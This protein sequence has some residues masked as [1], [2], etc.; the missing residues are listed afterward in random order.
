[1]RAGVASE[2]IR[3]TNAEPTLAENHSVIDR[4]TTDKS[5]KGAAAVEFALILTPLILLVFG[6]IYFSLYYN[7]LQGTQ[8]AA[9]E[10]AR[11]ASLRS[12]NSAMACASAEAALQGVPV[13]AGTAK[14]GVANTS[15]P[16]DGACSVTSFPCSAG[17]RDVFMRVRA[18]VTFRIPFVPTGAK[19]VSSTAKFRCE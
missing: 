8:A 12:S 17:N 15:N 18:S 19:T 2:K 10:G 9:R 4:F 3:P 13:D 14:F 5:E 7:A 11:L 6:I 16:P 1:M